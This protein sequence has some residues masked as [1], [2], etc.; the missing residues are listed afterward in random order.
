MEQARIENALSRI[1]RALARIERA[2]KPLTRNAQGHDGALAAR[3][4]A[5]RANVGRALEELDALIAGAS[6]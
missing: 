3:H 4:E 1:E 6:R 2:A 5:L